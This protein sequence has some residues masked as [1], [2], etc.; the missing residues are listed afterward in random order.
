MEG[1]PPC[2][3][4]YERSP[5]ARDA[6]RFPGAG[7]ATSGVGKPEHLQ[8]VERDNPGG[9]CLRPPRC[10]RNQHR[11]ASGATAQ[12][13]WTISRGACLTVSQLNANEFSLYYRSETSTGDSGGPAFLCVSRKSFTIRQQFRRRGDEARAVKTCLV[14][15]HRIRW[16]RKDP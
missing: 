3:D 13:W 1:L 7:L 8:Q 10:A 14:R 15:A 11:R 4:A 2:S 6:A 12:G 9:D 16:Q 5:F